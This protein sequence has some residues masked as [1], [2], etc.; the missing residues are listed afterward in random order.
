MH[1]KTTVQDGNY[2][3]S[4]C[5]K[6]STLTLFT[7][8]AVLKG[9]EETKAKGVKGEQLQVDAPAQLCGCTLALQREHKQPGQL[10]CS[11]GH[12]AES[13]RTLLAL[14]AIP[15]LASSLHG[16]APAPTARAA[17]RRAQAAAV[18]LADKHLRGDGGGGDA[19]W[20]DAV[21][22]W[23]L[24]LAYCRTEELRRW[25]LAQECELFRARF[26]AEPAASQ[27]RPPAQQRG[28]GEQSSTVLRWA[29]RL[30]CARGEDWPPA[31]QTPERGPEPAACTP[32]ALAG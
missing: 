9:L 1:C 30:V 10:A 6:G 19:R 29:L 27:A 14:T 21:S 2:R 25:F 20:R 4:W 24:R 13:R 11:C 17:A 31:E 22:H 7:L 8:C 5:T 12:L 3:S 15:G 28:P 16:S 18:A 26:R 32:A 23:V